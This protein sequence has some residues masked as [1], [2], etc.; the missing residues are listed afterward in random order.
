MRAHSIITVF[1]VTGPAAVPRY[2]LK[3]LRATEQ[4][5]EL[6]RV[7]AAQEYEL[8]RMLWH[9]FEP[10]GAFG[11][12]RPVAFWPERSSFLTEAFDGEKLSRFLHRGRGWNAGPA[13]AH[14]ETAV[15]HVG[16]WL[17][18]FQQFT[19]RPAT[20][21]FEPGDVLAYCERRLRVLANAR[22]ARVSARWA[23]EV[24]TRLERLG[25]LV[26]PDERRL[27]GCHNDFRPDNIVTD[28]RRIAVLDF[29]G[30]RPGPAMQDFVKFWMKLEDLR[31]GLSLRPRLVRRWQ[32]A[33]AD[34]YGE[35]VALGSPLGVLLRAANI[36][37][38]LSETVPTGAGR[39]LAIRDA[40]RRVLERSHVRA[41]GR[42]LEEGQ[43]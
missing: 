16:E 10:F 15:R 23:R 32:S 34:G 8:L 13:A 40:L 35:P 28:G 27:V 18:R 4:N 17:A 29:T 22:D 21:R 41:L 9:R 36:L 43:V 5:A 37:D 31:L 6:K 39:R 26:G 3:T 12:I 2:Y 1:R 11:V 7:Q 30:F 14:I 25:G 24:M 38:K 19:R 20:E 42:L 33:F